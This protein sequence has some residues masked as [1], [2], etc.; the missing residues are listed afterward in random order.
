MR[1]QLHLADPL[2]DLR[3]FRI[4]AFRASLVVYTGGILVLL[5]SFLYIPQY[6]QLVLEPLAARGGSGDAS[7][8]VAFVL[9]LLAPAFV[10]RMRPAWVMAGG[11]AIAAVGLLGLTQ[12]EVDSG[13]G[14]LIA[15]SFVYSL[16]IA[17]VFTLTNDLIIG[18][19]PPELRRRGLG[20]LRDR[21]RAGALSI[22]IL[23]T[24]GTVAYRTQVEDNIP[25]S[26]PPEEADAATD[27]LGGAVAASAD[28]G[29]SLAD[30][31]LE[32]A[33]TAFTHGFQVVALVSA[34]H[35]GP[36]RRRSRAL[37]PPGQ[38]RA[39][40][41]CGRARLTRPPRRPAVAA[42]GSVPSED[43]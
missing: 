39:P 24:L 23:G 20:D 14:V 16:G 41:G 34:D 15:T 32:V 7:S 37:P 3:L 21:R 28:L 18:A 2:I 43:Q 1:R 30:Q 17:P 26:V 27:T 10:K 9:G 40:R 13:L 8:F 36:G 42:E 11:L 33:R 35:G 22:A 19:A 6:L 5:G 38:G 31:V 25:A 12:V 29:D 4:P